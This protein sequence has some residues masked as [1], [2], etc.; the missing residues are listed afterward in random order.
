[1]D[2]AILKFLKNTSGTIEAI[3][4]AP[5]SDDSFRKLM[6]KIIVEEGEKLKDVLFGQDM[7]IA[8]K[9]GY[10][11]AV[12]GY[13]HSAE[14]NN[15]FLVER[16]SLSVFVK[17]TTE[18]Y[19]KALEKREWHKLVDEGFIIRSGGEALTRIRKFSG[20]RDVNGI[21][22][23][24]AGRPVCEKH[25]K[26]EDYSISV[27][28]LYKELG[29]KKKKAKNEI[30]CKYC[31]QE[32]KYFT[33]AMPKASALIA[34]ACET[35]GKKPNSLLKIYANL[36]RVLHP[37]GFTDLPKEKVFTIWAR[38][39]LMILLE[40]NQLLFPCDFKHSS[41]GSNNGKSAFHFL[42]YRKGREDG[43]SDVDGVS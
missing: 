31:K 29:M 30:S 27:H 21:T 35:V 3:S 8:M 22:I 10:K 23:Y 43:T 37:Y 26:W 36:S 24:F 2:K 42:K 39:L 25:L 28:E 15:R 33:L 34:L 12:L 17:N 13:L 6:K 9:A 18:A 7:I 4:K 5:P 40:I 32:A 11:N 38:D 41:R 19:R 1:M 20:S 16:A 14:E